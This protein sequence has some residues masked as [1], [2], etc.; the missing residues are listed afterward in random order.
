MAALYR[1]YHL[2]GLELGICV[3]SVALDGEPTGA[4]VERRAEVVRGG[5]ALAAG[6]SSTARAATRSGAASR[7]PA[8]PACRSGSPAG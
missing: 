7:P 5:R 1:P 6:R 2:I 3:A 8:P 4:P